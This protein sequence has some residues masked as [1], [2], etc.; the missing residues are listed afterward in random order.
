MLI[1]DETM[2]DFKKHVDALSELDDVARQ[3]E[4]T[5]RDKLKL[6][7]LSLYTE[8]HYGKR[9][10]ELK[11]TA[12]E[13]GKLGGENR[14]NPGQVEMPGTQLRNALG[15]PRSR[16]I[17]AQLLYDHKDVLDRVVK[18]AFTNNEKDLKRERVLREIRAQEGKESG[19][20]PDVK[21]HP[22]KTPTY[23]TV[24]GTKALKAAI[25][26]MASISKMWR[27]VEPKAQEEFLKTGQ[28]WESYWKGFVRILPSLAKQKAVKRTGTSKAKA[29]KRVTATSKSAA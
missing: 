4:G 29:T 2:D 20:K 15:W 11:P 16:A 21:T 9:F 18:Q 3:H 14:G 27:W 1:S 5:N 13:S 28:M 25:S 12:N 7:A 17:N 8:A 23:K 19:K 26:Y 6:D 22:G 10:R 24:E